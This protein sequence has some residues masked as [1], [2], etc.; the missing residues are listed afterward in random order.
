MRVDGVG[1]GASWGRTRADKSVASRGWGGRRAEQQLELGEQLMKPHHAHGRR[2]TLVHSAGHLPGQKGGRDSG[3]KNLSVVFDL[4][5][6]WHFCDNKQV[7]T[8]GQGPERLEMLSR[9]L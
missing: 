7:D 2:G 8:R 9:D 5:S 6:W 1:L 4:L 3:R